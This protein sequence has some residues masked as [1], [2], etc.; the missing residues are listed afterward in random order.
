MFRYVLIKRSYADK[1]LLPSY[2]IGKI[3]LMTLSSLEIPGRHEGADQRFTYRGISA[4]YLY[5]CIRL[6]SLPV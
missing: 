2:K 6:I 5:A 4:T 1:N 3:Y